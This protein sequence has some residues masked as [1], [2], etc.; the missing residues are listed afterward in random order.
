M[1]RVLIFHGFACSGLFVLILG[2]SFAFV[3]F[4]SL[5]GCRRCYDGRGDF[6]VSDFPCFRDSEILRVFVNLFQFQIFSCFGTSRN[7]HA[8][9]NT[10]IDKLG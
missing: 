7:T 8:V 2:F 9:Y 1:V 6:R 10:L 5:V 4:L 3:F